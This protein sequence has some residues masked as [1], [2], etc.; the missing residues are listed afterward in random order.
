MTTKRLLCFFST[1]IFFSCNTTENNQVWQKGNIHTHSLWSDGDDF[2]EM[3]IQWYKDND[4]Q[5]VALSDHNTVSDNQNR[6]YKIGE[7]EINNN[8]LEKYKEKFGDWV[9]EK[10]DESGTYARLKTFSEYQ[11]KLEEN[12]FLVIRSE[13]VTSGFEGK[14][15]HINVT[16]IQQKIEPFKGESVVDVMQQTL[17]AVHEQRK[18][19]NQPMFA[20]INHPNF[21]YGIN[22]DDLKKLNGERFFE[23]YNGHPA[24]NNEGNEYH[25]DTES[26]WD[27][28]NIHYYNNDKPLLFGIATD[29]SHNYHKQSTS[30]SNTGRGWVMVNTKSLETNNII[31]QMEAGNFYSS[32]GIYLKS[33]ASDNKG[34]SIEI[35]PEPNIEYGI[36][37]IGYKK[38]DE[39]T[40]LLKSFEGT[41]ANY[42]FEK[43][44]IFVRVKIVSTALM[45]NPYTDGETKKAWTQPIL[46][47]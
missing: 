43:E 40:K 14:P 24:V 15:V 27:L 6:W 38:G 28:I 34:I 10:I 2:P 13:E 4:Y 7:R 33:L 29:D 36:H 45:P 26:M 23:V 22:A 21:G 1:L 12:D 8:T 31:T 47:F 44:D 11:N 19:T 9:E 39:N 20:H 41:K 3:I 32:S 35:D 46:P 18:I 42:V 25:L 37:F 16:N 17:D 30:L 5:F